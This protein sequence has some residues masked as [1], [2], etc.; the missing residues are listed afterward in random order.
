M[1]RSGAVSTLQ[2]SP[3]SFTS[4]DGAY[5]TLDMSAGERVGAVRDH[6]GRV[7]A[8]SDPATCQAVA[9]YLAADGYPPLLAPVPIEETR[10]TNSK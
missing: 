3:P 8:F 7:V 5:F 9:H 1:V 4:A 6:S 2:C 10:A